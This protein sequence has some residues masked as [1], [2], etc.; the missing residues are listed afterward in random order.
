MDELKI[1]AFENSLEQLCNGADVP[2]RVQFYILNEFARRTLAASELE[3]QLALQN[4]QNSAKK[5]AKHV[6]EQTR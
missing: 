6:D 1:K 3:C 2:K 4:V 5:E